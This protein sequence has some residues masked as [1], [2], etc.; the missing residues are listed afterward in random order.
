MTRGQQAC[1]PLTTSESAYKI[2]PGAEV[3]VVDG[4]QVALEHRK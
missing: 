3:A 2:R 1:F 4:I